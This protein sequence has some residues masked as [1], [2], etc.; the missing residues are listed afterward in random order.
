ME[1][2]TA[3]HRALTLQPKDITLVQ[4]MRLCAVHHTIMLV[5]ALVERSIAVE[6]TLLNA[7]TTAE[8]LCKICIPNKQTIVI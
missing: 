3:Q 8:G 6:D 5:A 1:C 2:C 7:L 4:D